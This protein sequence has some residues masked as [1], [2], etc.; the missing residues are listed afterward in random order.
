MKRWFTLS[1]IALSLFVQSSAG[2]ADHPKQ[3]RVVHI[4]VGEG[5]GQEHLHDRDRRNYNF[6]A[7]R[8]YNR[9]LRR[10][11]RNLEEAVRQMQADIDLLLL[12]NQKLKQANAQYACYIKTPFDGT[13]LGRGSTLIEATAEALN[14]C[15]Q[16]AMSWCQER[17]VKCDK[18]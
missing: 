1:A 3:R 9:E 5:A 12:E 8:Y 11:V 17:K 7:H 13:F 6:K 16:K 18:A 4:Q 15:E 10:R 14:Q 2:H